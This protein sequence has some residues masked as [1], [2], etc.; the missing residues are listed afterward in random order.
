MT[1]YYTWSSDNTEKCPRCGIGDVPPWMKLC[2]DCS[3][4]VYD[5]EKVQ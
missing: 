5:R 4:E 3:K 1:H 2:P